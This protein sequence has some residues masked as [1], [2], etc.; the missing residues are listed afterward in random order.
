[1]TTNSTRLPTLVVTLALSRSPTPT[2]SPDE[3]PL[4]SARPQTF[5][6]DVPARGTTPDAPSTSST[7]STP[8]TPKKAP[9]HEAPSNHDQ[10]EDSIIDILPPQEEV[11][12]TQ[13]HVRR[14]P[15]FPARIVKAPHFPTHSPGPLNQ[16]SRISSAR[17]LGRLPSPYHQHI[18]LDRSL[19]PAG[20]SAPHFPASSPDQ[21]TPS[22]PS[23]IQKHGSN[24]L[25][26]P[27]ASKALPL[28]QARPVS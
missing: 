16:V 11:V 21:G 10:D 19:D 4:A 26:Q 2:F 3:P 5:W 27:Q 9:P 12:V 20:A 22:P 17:L 1:M 7:P 13:L 23:A 6:I 8:S 28:L 25:G 18:H 24:L 14:A 15:R